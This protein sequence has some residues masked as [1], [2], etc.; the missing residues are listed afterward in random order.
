MANESAEPDTGELAEDPTAQGLGDAKQKTPAVEVVKSYNKFNFPEEEWP[1]IEPAEVISVCE[2]G[3]EK[4]KNS[5]MAKRDVAVISTLT[6]FGKRSVE[7]TNLKFQDFAWDEGHLYVT[8]IVVKK[9]PK[10]TK[11]CVECGERNKSTAKLCNECGLDLAQPQ[12]VREVRREKSLEERTHPKMKTF[13]IDPSKVETVK[14]AGFVKAWWDMVADEID[15][16]N[17]GEKNPFMFP[18]AESVEGGGLPIWGTKLH[19]SSIK[20]MLFRYGK[21][22]GSDPLHWTPHYF[23]HSLASRMSIAL[24]AKGIDP[25][26]DL[27]DW[28]D[29][30]DK[31]MAEHYS[32]LGKKIRVKRIAKDNA[33]LLYK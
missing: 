7:I 14:L 4:Y 8:F 30:T 22:V 6:M 21:G 1:L 20:S 23:R 16:V 5:W 33:R 9:N 12:N 31:K 13:D 24:T 26:N 19:R 27:V 25:T 3:L 15:R 11:K 28:F 18:K 32:E 10:P 17:D 29:W 2:K